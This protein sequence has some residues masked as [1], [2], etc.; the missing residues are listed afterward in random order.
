M[1][2]K[3]QMIFQ[4]LMNL[5]PGRPGD[6]TEAWANP[7]LAKDLISWNQNTILKQCCGCLELAEKEPKRVSLKS[8]S[9]D[10]ILTVESSLNSNSDMT[11]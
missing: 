10:C 7:N 3:R 6:V 9:I 1:L 4:F 2:L 5:L 11:L 8:I